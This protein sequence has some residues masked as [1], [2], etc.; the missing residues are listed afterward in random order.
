MSICSS[1]PICH[2]DPKPKRPLPHSKSLQYEESLLPRRAYRKE[3]VGKYKA[4]N[5]WETRD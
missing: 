2:P 4:L 5:M 3:L 1:F